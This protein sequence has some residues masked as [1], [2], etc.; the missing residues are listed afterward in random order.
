MLAQTFALIEKE[1]L[2]LLRAPRGLVALIVPPLLQLMI[3]GYAATFDVRR[4]PIA[5]VNEDQGPQGRELAARFSG[6]PFFD[7]VAQP[8]RAAE[9]P[10]LIDRGNV[11]LAVR[12][13][14]RFSAE[15]GGGT[16]SDVQVIIDGRPLNTALSVQSYAAAVITRFNL[17]HVA[18]TGLPQPTALTVTRAWFNPNLL[19]HWYVVPGLVAK[20]L[21][22]VTLAGSA[23]AVARERDLGTFERLVAAPLTPL[24]LLVG[25]V[26]AAFAVGF[27]QG[28]AMSVLTALWFG[29]PFRGAF[30]L[31]AVSLAILLLSAI[32]IGLLISSL[33]RTQPR[34]I[35][36]TMIFIVPAVMMSGFA[37]PISS[38]PDWM[39]VLTLANPL[40]Y[41]IV[42]MRSV[43]LR[44]SGWEFVW[45]E[46][47]PMALIAF[48]TLAV[49][50]CML[51][52][53]LD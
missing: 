27:A 5:I 50:Y 4:A 49:S 20:L 9:I 17:D 26:V 3:F 1:L 24:Q 48:A 22:M 45:P 34:A 15:L 8:M 6:S 19:S 31:L 29:V 38:M 11:I 25:K 46:L 28:L 42:I 30:T 52:R 14:Q 32:G 12:I 40:R 37:I 39:Q 18:A 7:V 21:L 16:P 35:F 13:G 10:T 33:A 51:R 53:R 36:G 23:L 44:G 41:F 47:W 43:Y 2:V